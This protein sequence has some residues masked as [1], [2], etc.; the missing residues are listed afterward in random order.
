VLAAHAYGWKAPPEEPPAPDR[1]NFR[2]VE[3]LR[4]IMVEHGDASKPVLITEAGWNDHPRWTKAVESG[5]RIRYTLA[6]LDYA[7][8]NWPWLEALCLWA[9]RLP[10][11]AHNY[12]DYFTLV[13]PDFETKPIYEALRDAAASGRWTR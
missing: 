2:R 4:Q 6:A 5:Q 11:L 9:F 10:V 12:N 7:S 8:T 3:L 13:S 1:V